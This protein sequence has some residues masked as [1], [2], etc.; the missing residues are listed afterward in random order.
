MSTPTTTFAQWL[1]RRQAAE[2][3]RP[4]L[5]WAPYV[6]LCVLAMLLVAGAV[7]LRRSHAHDADPA[8]CGDADHHR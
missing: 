2:R 8:A 1:A 6:V 5:G 4:L 3:R 7:H